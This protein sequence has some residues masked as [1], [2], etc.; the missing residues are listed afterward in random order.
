MPS[1][2]GWILDA[3]MWGV[4][5]AKEGYSLP[6]ARRWLLNY[7]NNRFGILCSAGTAVRITT[8]FWWGY[9]AFKQRPEFWGSWLQKKLAQHPLFNKEGIL[10][11]IR[12]PVRISSILGE[13]YIE[14]KEGG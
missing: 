3:R 2:K 1:K 10:E 12:G 11:G 5:V 8:K 4:A 9:N 6:K 13:E 14:E 7:V